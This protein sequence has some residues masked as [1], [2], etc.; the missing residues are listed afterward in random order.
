M[1]WR[2]LEESAAGPDMR[3]LR[4]IFAERKLLIEKYVPADILTL[5][6]SVIAGLK[7]A[8]LAALSLQAG[9]KAP[10]FELKDHSGK[11]VSS[12]DLLT[13]GPLVICFF[14]GRWDSFCCGQM[15]ALNGVLPQITAAGARLVGI[16]PQTVQQSF[17]M[18]DQ[19]R[20]GFPLLSGAGN[21]V[22]RAFR[23]VYQVPEDQK[24]IYQRA[25]VNLPFVNG[26]ASWELP[27]PATY[28]ADR[29]GTVRFASADEDYSVRPEPAEIVQ[30]LLSLP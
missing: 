26:D 30:R 2:G 9:E 27:I 28:V 3:P 13:Q 6:T 25:F 16:S 12:A 14:R 5:H 10:A 21:R 24:A 29:A 8:R 18:A 20:L 7:Q 1:K 17:F 22:A 11:L 23:L 15:E 4:E 19:H